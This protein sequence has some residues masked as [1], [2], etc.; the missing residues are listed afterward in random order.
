M[1]IVEDSFEKS[2]PNARRPSV[3][4]YHGRHP[5]VLI[6]A[7]LVVVQF[8]AEGGGRGLGVSGGGSVATVFVEYILRFRFGATRP[9]N[10]I[11]N[12]VSN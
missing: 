3:V 5:L 11:S 8:I 4:R 1:H 12:Y 7:A 2:L 9:S 10:G 6:L